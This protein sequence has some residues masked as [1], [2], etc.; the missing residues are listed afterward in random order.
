MLELWV[1]CDKLVTTSF[2][3]I[4]EYHPGIVSNAFKKLLL[5]KLEEMQRLRNVEVYLDNRTSEA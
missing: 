4:K 2:P 5:S 3:M 1:A